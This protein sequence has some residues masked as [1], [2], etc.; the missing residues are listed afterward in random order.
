MLHMVRR[1]FWLERI[2][3]AW[4]QK[5]IVW[6]A[7]VR[8]AGKTFLARSLGETNFLDCELPRVRRDLEDP[9]DFFRHVTGRRIVFDEIHRLKNPAELLKI[10]ADHFP[11]LRILATGSS[12]LA[13]TRKFR[14]TLTDRKRVIHLTPMIWQDL[15]DFRQPDLSH[16]FLQGGLP[17]FF[18]H[19][20]SLDEDFTDWMDSY[21]SKDIQALFR[22]DRRFAFLRFVELIFARSGG[23]F[24]ATSFAAD[25]EVSRPTIHNFLSALETTFV[26]TRVRPY[27]TRKTT[28][29]VAAPRVYAFDTG[30]VCYYRGWQTLRPDDCGPLWEHLVLNEL[31]AHGHAPSYWRTKQGHEIDFVLAPRG[32]APLAIECKWKERTFS[33]DAVAAFRRYYPGG[34]NLLVVSDAVQPK[35]RSVAGLEFDV[36]SI[37]H[38]GKW[39]SRETSSRSGSQTP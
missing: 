20:R 17:P 23:I 26:A 34:K 3:Q 13:A 11:H 16:R 38:L 37:S 39:L 27:S 36:C 10:A 12:T 6:L 35:R 15:L 5:S 8:R 29:I 28:E 7:G 32:R 21:W 31:L 24:E 19:P 25:C 33:A 9:E 18:M 30:F 2:A 1:D 22:F 14:D 4:R